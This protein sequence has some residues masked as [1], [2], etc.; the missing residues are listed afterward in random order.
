MNVL[1]LAGRHVSLKRVSSTKGG[2]YTGP[3]PGCGGTDRFHVW[4]EDKGGEGGYWCRQCEKAGDGIQF[5]IDF[6][7]KHFREA[8]AIL[9]RDLPE[10][11]SVPQTSARRR[12]PAP[13]QFSPKPHVSP[14]DQWSERASKLVDEAHARIKDQAGA[15]KWLAGRGISEAVV[16]RFRLGWLDKNYFRT[17]ESWG[18]ETVLRDDGKPKKLFIPRG[19]LI[20]SFADDSVFRLRVRRPKADIDDSRNQKKYY[21]VPGSSPMALTAGDD[22]RAFVIVETELDAMMIHGLAG[23]LV[24]VVAMGSSSTKPDE[25]CH[26]VLAKAACILVSLDFDH[27]GKTAWKFWKDTYPESERWPVSEGKDPGEAYE[28]GVDIR[29]WVLAGLPPAWHVAVPCRRAPTRVAD[30]ASES[31]R[32]NNVP[33]LPESVL[34][35]RD[36]LTRYPVRIRASSK[37]LKM[38]TAENFRNEHILKRISQLMFMDASCF[39]YLN[40]HPDDVVDGRNFDNSI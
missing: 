14:V 24:G 30:A 5:L 6:E 9:G 20:P 16:D 34:E 29:A 11:S 35:L 39:E 4:P 18:V 36:L 10:G 8:C 2:E 23:D 37:S 12:R 40:G 31:K 7:G 1:E 27:A 28:R 32:A 22:A 33:P 19:I 21:V 25:R 13:H 3:C 17:R 26:A 38:L 15:M